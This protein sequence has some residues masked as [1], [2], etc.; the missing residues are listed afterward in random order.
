[1]ADP[2]VAYTYSPGPLRCF[3]DAAERDR[4]HARLGH[5]WPVRRWQDSQQLGEQWGTDDIE[6]WHFT[7]SKV[8]EHCL[9]QQDPEMLRNMGVASTT[10][11]LIAMADAFNGPGSPVNFWGM[12]YGSLIGTHLLQSTFSESTILPLT[13][14]AY[15]RAAVFPEVRAV[16]LRARSMVVIEELYVAA[17]RESHPGRPSRPD[18]LHR[19]AILPGQCSHISCAGSC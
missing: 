10:R 4:F 15:Q 11:D 14:C 16:P 18:G 13:R 8:V 1:M 17:R 7:Q 19:T 3:K 12:S 2:N 6:K 5:E 9:A